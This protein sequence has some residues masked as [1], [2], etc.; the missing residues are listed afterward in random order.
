MSQGLYR[1]SS[2]IQA[3]FSRFTII[4]TCKFHLVECDSQCVNVIH[5]L[6]GHLFLPD[7]KYT[8]MALETWIN[9]EAASCRIHTGHILTL[10]NV[11][12]Y[13]FITIIPMTIVKVLTDQRVRL[14]CS[15]GVYL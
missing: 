8:E 5:C 3:Y 13:Q 10:M 4:T 12:Q 9:C 6:V 11:F 7:S 14:H 1:W 15:I 2:V